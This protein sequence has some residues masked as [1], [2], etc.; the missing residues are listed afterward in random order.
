[1]VMVTMM[2]LAGSES[3]ACAG[4]HEKR[5]EDELL[6]ALKVPRFPNMHIAPCE[7]ESRRTRVEP[8]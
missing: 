4:Q 6:H 7:K 5:E 1:M 3:R 2:M 8:R